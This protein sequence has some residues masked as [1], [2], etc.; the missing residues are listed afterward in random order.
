[1]TVELWALIYVTALLIA[2]VLIQTVAGIFSNGLAMQA[3]NRGDCPPPGKFLARATRTVDNHREGLLMF[4][5]LVLIGAV[6][7]VSTATTVLGAQLF[8]WTRVA[9]AALYLIGVPWLRAGAW[10][11]GMAGIV[12]VL[13]GVLGLA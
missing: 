2:L 12:M 8:L 11:V 10:G 6:I 7:D 13:I 4:A 1:M 3:S 5:P 9:H